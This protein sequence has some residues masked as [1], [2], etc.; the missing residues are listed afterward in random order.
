MKLSLFLLIALLGLVLANPVEPE[1]EISDKPS[2]IEE[3]AERVDAIKQHAIQASHN[4]TKNANDLVAS[5]RASE[6]EAAP[7]STDADC[8]HGQCSAETCQCNLGFTN[9]GGQACSYEQKNKVT[10]FLLSLFLGNFGADWFYLAQENSN[11]TWAGAVKLMTGLFFFVSS[12]FMCC[13]Q[14]CFAKLNESKV[15]LLVRLVVGGLALVFSLVNLI[16]YFI[17]WIRIL[18]DAFPDGNHVGLKPW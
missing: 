4:L 15:G 2:P 7:C 5:L 13:A 11:Y 14:I 6:S 8:G 12:C 10:A 17:D 18:A 3:V 1:T 9:F 16:W